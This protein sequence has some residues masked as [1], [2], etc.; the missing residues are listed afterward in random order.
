MLLDGLSACSIHFLNL[1]LAKDAQSEIRMYAGAVKE[2][3]EKQ[4]GMKFVLGVCLK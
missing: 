4:D 2:I 1:R 3:F